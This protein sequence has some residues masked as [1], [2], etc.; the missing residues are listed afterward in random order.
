M[1]R[2]IDVASPVPGSLTRRSQ[3]IEAIHLGRLAAKCLAAGLQDIDAT[4]EI[5]VEISR[6]DFRQ[7]N[8]SWRTTM[9]MKVEG[10]LSSRRAAAVSYFRGK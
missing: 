8:G 4:A 10:V 3:W 2:M 9:G 5:S 7:S 6:L 1:A